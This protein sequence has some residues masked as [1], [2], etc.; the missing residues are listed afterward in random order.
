M[1]TH[2]AR[3]QVNYKLHS[4]LK[5][6]RNKVFHSPNCQKS[7]NV[8]IKRKGRYVYNVSSKNSACDLYITV[9]EEY[10]GCVFCICKLKFHP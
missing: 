5:P 6:H 8:S 4:N 7:Q 10:R 2:L 1:F 3:Q 9:M